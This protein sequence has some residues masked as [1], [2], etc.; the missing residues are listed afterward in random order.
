MPGMQDRSAPLSTRN[1]WWVVVSS[2]QALANTIV[3]G[4]SCKYHTSPITTSPSIG[5]VVDLSLSASAALL[6]IANF[7]LITLIAS[8]SNRSGA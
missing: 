7:S 2:G 8:G 3:Y 5:T 6:I 4:I 1:E